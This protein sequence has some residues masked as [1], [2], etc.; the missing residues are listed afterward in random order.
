MPKILF[1][2]TGGISA[3]KA[4]ELA[5]ELSKEGHELGVVMTDAACKFI[6]PLSFSALTGSEVYTSESEKVKPFAHLEL[7][8]EAN[9][10]IVVPATANTITKYA[11]GFADNLLLSMLLAFEG[12]VIVCPA[13]NVKM[14]ETEQVQKAINELESRGVRVV[15]PE[16]GRLACGDE[17]EGRLANIRKIHTTINKEL[18]IIKDLKGKKIVVTSGP[19]REWLDEIRFISNASSG[20]MGKALAMEALKRGA[21]V[22]YITGPTGLRSP[23]EAQVIQVETADEMLRACEEHVKN[24]DILFMAAAVSDF[25]PKKMERG[26]IKKTESE[27]LE[28]RLEKTQ[29]ILYELSK[30]K[31]TGQIYVGFAL[32]TTELER[33]A[34]EK[35]N[36]KNL[37][38]I[39]ANIAKESIG[40]ETISVAIYDKNGL[41]E[42]LSNLPKSSVAIRLIELSSGLLH[43]KQYS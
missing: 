4:L 24:A 34:L 1:G 21:K 19:T 17:G 43:A 42:K 23:R 37:D 8:K 40:K 5:R 28:I 35:L 31:K 25:R 41:I 38:L 36:A 20:K 7:T 32:E 16:K 11:Y 6:G 18:T 10:A 2:V 14:W 26:K 3:Y 15:Y 33:Y 27:F 9:I 13:M 30:S 39:V 22:V 12:P 29:D